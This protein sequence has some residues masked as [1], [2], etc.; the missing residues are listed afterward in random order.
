MDMTCRRNTGLGGG[1]MEVV[2]ASLVRVG[3]SLKRFWRCCETE[4]KSRIG[5][6]KV[7]MVYV[8]W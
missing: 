4:E 8:G 3:F 1:S 5:R 2:K 7:D 6:V